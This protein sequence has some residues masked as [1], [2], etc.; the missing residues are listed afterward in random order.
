M[1]KKNRIHLEGNLKDI[2]AAL[3]SLVVNFAEKESVDAN[4]TIQDGLN[5]PLTVSLPD[6]ARLFIPN[7]PPQLKGQ[8]VQR[9]INMTDIYTGQHFTLDLDPETFKDDHIDT[10]TYE[11][12]VA[13][14]NSSELPKWLSLN[15]LRLQGHPPEEILPDLELVLIA[16]NEF[17]QLREPFTLKV[18]ISLSFFL[19]L[20]LRYG[21]YVISF[22]G[23]VISLNK[24]FNIFARKIYKHPKE[25]ILNP[26]EKITSENI[27]PIF[28][29]NKE[30][31]EAGLILKH[32]EKYISKQLQLKSITKPKLINYFMDS[33]SKELDK[34]SII[35]TIKTVIPSLSLRN[36]QELSL[37][38]SAQNP[39]KPLIHQLIIDQIIL[40]QLDHDKGTKSIFNKVKSRWTEM[41]YWDISLSKF[42]LNNNKFENIVQENYFHTR[43][44]SSRKDSLL[45]KSELSDDSSLFLSGINL[46]LLGDSIL[47]YAFRI[48]Q[49]SR[50]PAR[51]EVILKEKVKSNLVKRFLKRDLKSNYKINYGINYEI[52]DDVLNFSGVAKSNVEGKTLVVQILTTRNRILKEIWIRGA[53]QS[54]SDQETIVD[55]SENNYEAY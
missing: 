46:N 11:L 8:T 41:I 21:S 49:I 18:K 27:S 24:I 10:L 40:W 2:N 53:P 6:T 30:K 55:I 38:C 25:Y 43:P 16:K 35:K 54:I 20:L 15:G 14:N 42:A 23:L 19:K 34:Q 48:H 51:V 22:I 1:I 52:T 47:A 33:T 44:S 3:H 12:V 28:F 17:K 29:I 45:T 7:Q 13:G 9:Q 37:Y 50:E 32:L 36:K 26:G 5:K 39:R 31:Q 4:I